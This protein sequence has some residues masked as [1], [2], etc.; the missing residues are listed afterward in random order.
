MGMVEIVLGAAGFIGAVLYL[1]HLD[2][3]PMPWKV[4]R[5]S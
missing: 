4:R 3:L 5:E 1:G 2:G